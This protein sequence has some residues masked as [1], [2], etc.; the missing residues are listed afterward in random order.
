MRKTHNLK[1]SR[2]LQSIFEGFSRISQPEQIA[3]LKYLDLL[4]ER[5][6]P[7]RKLLV[8]FK[9]KLELKLCKLISRVKNAEKS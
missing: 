1:P 4:I 7:E 2:S 3:Y 8:K 5:N 9:A 6:A